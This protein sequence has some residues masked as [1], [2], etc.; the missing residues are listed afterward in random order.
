ME[1]QIE[2]IDAFEILDSRGYPTLRVIVA[3]GGGHRGVASVPSGASTGRHEVIELR[4]GDASRYGGKGVRKAVSNIQTVIREALTGR[5]ATAQEAIDQTLIALDGTENK[6][7]LGANA[8]LGVSMAAAQAAASALDVPLYAHLGGASAARLPVP[9][10]NVIN[11]GRH[12]QNS[13][14]F[15]EFMIV[16]HG[17]PTF[18]EALRYGA[19][20]FH[21][22]KAQL[23]GAGYSTAVGDEGGFAPNLKSVEAACELIV[24]AIRAAGLRPG[25]D[26][27][28]ALD[29]AASS[30]A[31][32][33]TYVFEKSDQREVS[34]DEMLALYVRLV[35]AFPIVS[36]ED[37]FAEDD[38][39]GFRTQ[40]AML[41]DRVQIVGDDLYVTNTRFIQRGIE[42]R[43]TNAVL[44]KPN[45]IGTVSET[46]KAVQ[47][48]REA[49]WQYVISHRSGETED[50]FISD[51]AVAM[52]GGQIK[53]GS[54]SRSERLAKYNRLLEIERELGPSA[55]YESPFKRKRRIEERDRALHWSRARHHN[56]ECNR[57]V[58]PPPD[59]ARAVA[60]LTSFL[61]GD[62]GVV[63]AVACGTSAIPLLRALLFQREPSGL[64]QS[65]CRAVEAL[66]GLKA[67][68]V[69]IE[70]LRAARAAGDPVERLGDD[71]VINAAALASAKVGN[72]RVFGLL[73]RLAERPA[74]T[75]VIAALGS[76]NRIEAIPALVS[77]LEDDASRRTAETALKRLGRAAR[78]ALIG[79]TKQKLPSSAHES[80]SSLR[81][82][83]SAIALLAEIGLSRRLWPEVRPLL[84]DEDAR[85][86]VPACKLCL[87]HG[88][89]AE[90]RGAISRMMDLLR[91][92]DWMLREE[93]AKCLAEGSRRGPIEPRCGQH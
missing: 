10:M 92:V 39:E 84:Q 22:L 26:V 13:L 53:A 91:R 93:I 47:M 59:P 74:L 14:D 56:E 6:S 24:D 21:A 89:P 2:D 64:F 67:Y 62:Q 30:F 70:Y 17:A 76:F 34:R 23:H 50:T 18:A 58:E 19:E 25:D 86:S 42:E 88:S 75:G 66:A 8:I 31:A 5:D 57:H 48:C 55:V 3:L 87:A 49:G 38:W 60:R 85:V 68:D 73:L 12:A 11:G 20:T 77:A 16:P 4:D 71:A 46:T 33:G 43:A 72:D 81:R 36:I 45:Q 44:I 15:Q 9:M 63:E 32:N 41:G 65:R 69:L 29:P 35:D 1:F 79:S 27:A 28:L 83:R 82:R 37:G 78:P 80:E 51:F 40:T 54:L 52:G 7:K 90:K 61:D